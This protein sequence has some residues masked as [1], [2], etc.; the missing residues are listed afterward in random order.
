MANLALSESSGCIKI[1]PIPVELQSVF[2]NTGFVE[3]KRAS[4]GKEVI[5][6]LRDRYKIYNIGAQAGSGMA[7]LPHLLYKSL[8]GLHWTWN[9]GIN[10][11]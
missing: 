2:K 11:A 6:V 10:R 8:N 5:L 3:S 9:I 1:Y 4:K 7:P